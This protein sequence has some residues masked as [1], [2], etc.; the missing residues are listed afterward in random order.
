MAYHFRSS[1]ILP[2][3]NRLPAS[4]SFD[5]LYV[6]EGF[7]QNSFT[8]SPDYL[9]T[10]PALHEHRTVT[11]TRAALYLTPPPVSQRLA[12]LCRSR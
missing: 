7:T 8:I 11:A 5:Y 4:T 2:L 6:L 10:L 1:R 12:V 3:P 9:R